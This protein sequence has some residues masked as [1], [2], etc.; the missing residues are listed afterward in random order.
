MIKFKKAIKSLGGKL[1]KHI[2]PVW[3]CVGCLVFAAITA[4]AA[5]TRV[6][7]VKRV[8]STSAGAGEL[9]SSNYL[10]TGNAIIRNVTFS[11]ISDN[12]VVNVTVCNY[13]QTNNAEVNSDDINYNIK[14][15]LVDSEG[16]AITSIPDEQTFTIKIGDE[17]YTLSANYSV[18]VTNQTLAGGSANTNTYA[19]TFPAAQLTSASKIYVKLTAAPD[20]STSGL[21]ALSGMIGVSQYTQKSSSWSGVFSETANSTLLDGFN[22]TVSGSGSGTI[23]LKWNVAYVELGDAS[24][25]ELYQTAAELD[26]WK[27]ITFKVDSTEKNSYALQFYR[28]CAVPSDEAWD[29]SKTNIV[30]ASSKYIEFVFTPTS[31]D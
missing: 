10:Q 12:P 4:S 5:Y 19:I 17:T 6:S 2:L 16:K 13:S 20:G 8:V 14:A 30:A 15:E 18:E 24:L 22:Y 1:K 11:S 9:F 29:Y 26:N 31:E 25:K 7:Y 23:T 21:T 27:T 3:I 28:T